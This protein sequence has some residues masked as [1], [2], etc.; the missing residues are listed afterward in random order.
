[1]KR[2]SK[3]LIPVLLLAV[4]GGVVAWLLHTGKIGRRPPPSN[5]LTLYGNVDIRQVELGFRVPGRLKS[6]RFEEGGT[7]NAGAVMAELDVRSFEDQL[8][9]AEAQVAANK[10]NLNK[11]V[12]GF[13]PSE[14]SRAKA[15]LDEATAAQQY[16]RTELGRAEKLV[17]ANAI[18]RASYDTAL[19]ASHE[20]NARAASASESLR[21]FVQGSRAED[22]AAARAMLAVAQANVA[23]A[24]TA[25]ADTRLVAPSDGIVIS[26][27][28]EPGAIVS[29]NDPVY[30]V[31]LTHSVWVRAYVSETKLGT[32]H[33]GMEVGVTSDAAP[34]RLVRGHVGFISP[35][36][37]FTPKSVETPELRTDLVYRIRIIVDDVDA[38]L[39]QGMPVTVHIA[40]IS[41][42][43]G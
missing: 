26:R 25:I 32:L 41:G 12:A 17:A 1:M 9:A 30:V 33:P 43:G 42:K 4:T 19:A 11:V 10:A 23:S 3:A 34:S 21:L 28:K 27:V 35:T 38:G 7:V 24:Q 14:I 16:A 29:P 40:T 2:P 5:I 6:M 8:H 31:S 39:R 13:R 22:I 15:A 37:E 18:P 20:A 36:A